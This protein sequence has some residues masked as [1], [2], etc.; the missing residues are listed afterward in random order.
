M[1][2]NMAQ[3]DLAMIRWPIDSRNGRLVRNKPHIFQGNS[4]FLLA[5]SSFISISLYFFSL[6]VIFITFSLK[7]QF[8]VPK[9]LL[10]T[11]EL[12]E[13]Q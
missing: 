2:N 4:T 6:F 13:P 9:S 1:F 3:C 5:F 8:F 12:I 10:C 11:F 7:T